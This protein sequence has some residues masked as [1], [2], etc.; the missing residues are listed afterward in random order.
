MLCDGRTS[1]VKEQGNGILSEPEGFVRIKQLNAIFPVL[2]LSWKIR[3]S[4]VLFRMVRLFSIVGRYLESSWY[5]L[6]RRATMS[7]SVASLGK[8]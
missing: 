5:I 8:L 3:N 6:K 2:K 7:D 4:A 1:L